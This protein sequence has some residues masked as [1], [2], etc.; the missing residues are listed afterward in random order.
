MYWCGRYKLHV[1]M[2]PLS[3]NGGFDM[4]WVTPKNKYCEREDDF[5]TNYYL[6]KCYITEVIFP[7]Q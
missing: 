1:N 3:R 4:G 2:Y 5:C 6:Q 7:T